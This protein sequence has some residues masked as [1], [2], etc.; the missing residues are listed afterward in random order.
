MV[1]SRAN[2][3]RAGACRVTCGV[4]GL[5]GVPELTHSCG[6][7]VRFPSG[8]EGKRGKCPH[9]GG[10][11]D[12]PVSDRIPA[13]KMI[14]LQPPPHWPEY[15]A[16]LDGGPPPRPMVM[17][18]KLMLQTEADDAWDRQAQ[19]RPSKFWCPSCKDRM[20]VDQ[21]ICT[22]CGLDFRTGHVLGQNVK[23]NEK[24]MTYLQR[25]PWLVDARDALKEELQSEQLKKQT[26]KLRGKAPTR[27]KRR[28]K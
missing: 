14:T 17:P 2:A 4:Q 24:G 13:Q 12:V 28:S 22:K 19:V 1:R 7:T 15:Q 11:V 21:V 10:R 8:T 3:S 18:H 9:C 16:Y 5:R 25:I 23:L 20:D 26:G 27:R 6:K